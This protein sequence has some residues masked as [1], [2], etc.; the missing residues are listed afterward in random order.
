MRACI[1][2]IGV[3]HVGAHVAEALL[4]RGIADELRL[5]DQNEVLSCSQ[6]NDLADALS[7]HAH[8][9][10]VV[11]CGSR[12]EELAECDVIINAAGHIRESLENRDGELFTTPVEVRSFARRITDAGFSGVWLTIANPCDVVAYTLWRETGYD[13]MKILGTG[14]SLD[15]ARL[16]HALSRVTGYDQRSITAWMLGEHGFSEFACWS[17]ARIGGLTLEEVEAQA[18]F[19][20]DRTQLNEEALRGGY[21]SVKG[22]GCTEYS[23]GNAAATVVDAIVRDAR[24]IIP[25]STLV[26][27]VYDCPQIFTSLPCVVGAGGVQQQ[28]VPQLSDNEIAAW[29]ASCTHIR[30]NIDALDWLA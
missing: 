28:F 9:A 10:R 16:A 11:D 2:I 23:I 7:F 5:C 13:P 1:G 4:S 26:E 30:E 3:S 6:R 24:S 17:H 27:G 19:S 14:T 22:K 29:Q 12:Y 18:S 8:A 25:V 15:S 21:V 20:F